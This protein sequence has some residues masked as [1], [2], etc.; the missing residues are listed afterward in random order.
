MKNSLLI[1]LLLVFISLTTFSCSVDSLEED[2]V[3]INEKSSVISSPVLRAPTTTLYIKWERDVTE[4]EKNQLRE[5]L[6]RS[7]M[8]IQLHSF[9]IDTSLRN[10]EKWE[11]TFPCLGCR[12]TDPILWL[13]DETVIDVASTNPL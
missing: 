6:I 5:Q 1:S 8:H 11:V 13:E 9:S 10:H 7:T 12:S 2:S 3:T 4:R